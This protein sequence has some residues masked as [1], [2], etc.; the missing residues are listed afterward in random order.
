MDVG[1]VCVLFG[2]GYLCA[3]IFILI[4]ME[5]IHIIMGLGARQM[6][7]NSVAR[8]SGQASFKPL[9]NS[10]QMNLSF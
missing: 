7:P 5:G 2:N 9:T 4:R 6:L 3:F 8:V 10:P 1:I